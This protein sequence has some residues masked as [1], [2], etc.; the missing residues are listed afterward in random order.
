[1]VPIVPALPVI[2]TDQSK[3]VKCS[4]W[5]LLRVC[6]WHSSVCIRAKPKGQSLLWRV[7]ARCRTFMPGWCYAGQQGEGHIYPFYVRTALQGIRARRYS[8]C[9]YSLPQSER[10]GLQGALH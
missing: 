1:M 6:L 10:C 3:Q 5:I 7:P 8:A 2:G 4:S 9:I